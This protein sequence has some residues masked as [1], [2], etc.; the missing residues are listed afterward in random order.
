M[1]DGK[2][3]FNALLPVFFFQE[4]RT[5]EGRWVKVFK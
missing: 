5:E 1:D 3:F 4:Y 2:A